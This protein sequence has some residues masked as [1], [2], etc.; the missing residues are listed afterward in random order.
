MYKN[1]NFDPLRFNPFA[2]LVLLVN[3]DQSMPTCHVRVVLTKPDLC[4]DEDSS[5]FDEYKGFLVKIMAKIKKF[6]LF[7]VKSNVLS[8]GDSI[9]DIT[10]TIS[11]F[12]QVDL[13]GVRVRTQVGTITIRVN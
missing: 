7:V 12:N 8:F 5:S 4:S 3:F 2:S 13:W 9:L 11:F 10:I 1:Y 6:K